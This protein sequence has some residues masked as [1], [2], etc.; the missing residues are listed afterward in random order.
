MTGKGTILLYV[1]DGAAHP[2]ASSVSNP[3]ESIVSLT[4][5]GRSRPGGVP[6]PFLLIYTDHCD[7]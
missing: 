3:N 6:V 2:Q 4:E 1:T 5:L 7:G